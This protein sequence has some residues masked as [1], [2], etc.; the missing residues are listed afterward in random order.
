MGTHLAWQIF[1]C[2]KF[3]YFNAIIIIIIIAVSHVNPRSQ[4]LVWTKKKSFCPYSCTENTLTSLYAV[5]NEPIKSK[6]SRGRL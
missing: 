5:A 4:L 1:W 2:G 3:N 6:Y